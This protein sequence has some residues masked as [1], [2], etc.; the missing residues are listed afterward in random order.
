MRK[1]LA[2]LF[3]VLAVGVYG[4]GFAASG[5]PVL[6]PIL[7][8]QMESTDL[9]GSDGTFITGTAGTDT[10]GAVW[11]ADGDLVDGAGVP[12]IVDLS[13]IAATAIP[14]SL[15]SDTAATDDLGTEALYWLKAY[16]GTGISFEGATDDEFQTSIVITDP[17]ADRSITFPNSDETIGVAT[18]AATDAIDAI[19]EIASALKSGDDA[20]LITGTAGASGNIAAW[21]ADGDIVDGGSTSPGSLGAFTAIE[22]EGGIA[23]I[24]T[25]N[26]IDLDGEGSAADDITELAGSVVG[27]IVVIQNSHAAYTLT[28]KDGTYLLLQGDF[29]LDDIGDS[30]T[31]ICTIAGANETYAEL[32]RASNG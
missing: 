18:S 11:N 5:D 15:I 26:F 23:T 29:L 6:E 32:T 20:T 27:D 17:T 16:L 2:L 1:I 21:N 3:I 25:A 4:T 7:I 8:T 12:A 9:S 22:A 19:T 10:Y 24:G 31:L 28:M 14:V 13:N 30:I